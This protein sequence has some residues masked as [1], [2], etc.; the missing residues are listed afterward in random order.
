MGQKVFIYSIPR[1]TATGIDKWTNDTSGRSLQKTKVGTTATS[2]RA[3][4]SDRVGGLKNGLSYK[5]W[6]DD[7]G[8]T[9]KDENGNPL[10]LQDKME[11]KWNKPKGF[12][13]N[14]IRTS[15]EAKSGVPSSYFQTKRWKMNDG[16]TML[17]LDNM[18]EEMGYYMMLDSEKVANSETE[19][20][21]HKWPHAEFYVAL[22]NESEE[23]KYGRNERK[24]KAFAALHSEA[25]NDQMKRKFCVLLDMI[26]TSSYLSVEQAH[27]LLFEYIDKS[28]F[29]T[30]SNLSKFFALYNRLETKDGRE[31]IECSY[32]LQKAQDLRII[33]EKQGTHTWLSPEGP[34]EIGNT[35][36]EA[37]EFLLNPKKQ[38]QVL[39]IEASIK[40]R[41]KQ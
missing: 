22:A 30:E 26:S 41:E 33:L 31:Y 29:G 39:Q 14:R 32:L 40:E 15:E 11:K 38:S 6:I 17:D 7:A 18:D 3:V 36:N 19:W 1:A 5:P 34:L 24:S 2:L 4:Y 35:R 12:F 8:Q 9:V 10:T 20:R 25:M 16:A 37:I 27:N 21:S 23:I 13:H 28:G